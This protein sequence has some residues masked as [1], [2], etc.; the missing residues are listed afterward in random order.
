MSLDITRRC[1]P[2]V[3]IETLLRIESLPMTRFSH[4]FEEY[5]GETIGNASRLHASC[6]SDFAKQFPAIAVMD[7]VLAANRNYRK[8][9]EK[10]VKRMSEQFGSLTLFELKRKIDAND[11][12]SFKKI[13][14]H[15]DEKKFMTL[16]RI[17]GKIIEM[18]APTSKEDDFKALSD[19]A[20]NA[21][22]E[23]W[24]TDPIGQLG[25]VGVATF[26]HLRMNFGVDTVKPDQRVMEVLFKEFN[27]KLSPF[28]SILAVQQIASITN[29][30][31]LEIDQVFVKYGSGYYPASQ[32]EVRQEVDNIIRILLQE[33]IPK[34]IIAKATKWS[35][36]Q[37]DKLVL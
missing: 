25:N 29:R 7:V 26:Q 12:K 18:N 24:S 36:N 35:I 32:A 27:L 14:G 3:I 16:K 4:G 13:W 19:W 37:I 33:N 22:L 2:Q 34:D 8:Q 6:F 30:R 9:V 21:N 10:H 15:A 5:K 20:Q 11:Y 23:H 28:D 1:S 17:V 31:V